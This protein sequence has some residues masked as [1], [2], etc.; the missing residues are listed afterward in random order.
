MDMEETNKIEL[1][2]LDSLRLLSAFQALQ[3]PTG[4]YGVTH[5]Q[6]RDIVEQYTG[7]RPKGRHES[8]GDLAHYLGWHLGCEVTEGAA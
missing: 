2:G 5:K 6:A 4:F 7:K 8:S 1:S 3:M